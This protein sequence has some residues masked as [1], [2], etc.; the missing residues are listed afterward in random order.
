L[1]DED[2]FTKAVTENRTIL[3]FDLDFAEILATAGSRV[4]SVVL[5]RLRN[6]RADHVIKRLSAAFERAV[7]SLERGAV[8]IVEEA[9]IRIRELP[10]SADE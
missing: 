1:P 7:E 5:F 4:P 2:V 6:A 9:R 8:V 3:T 10:I